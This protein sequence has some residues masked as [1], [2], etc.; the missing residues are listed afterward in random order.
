M[1]PMTPEERFESARLTREMVDLV[2]SF[3][4]G[5]TSRKELSTW[6]RDRPDDHGTLFRT[7][8][9]AGLHGCLWNCEVVLRE[10]GEPL[11]RPVDLVEHLHVVSEG[12]MPFDPEEIAV[13]TPGVREIARYVAGSATRLLLDGLGWFEGVQFASPATGRPFAAISL[14][15]LELGFGDPAVGSIVRTYRYPE[16]AEARGS[17]LADLFDTL[18]IDLDDVT[19]VRGEVS[20]RWALMRV[21]DNGNSA[22]V[23]AFSGYAKARTRLAHFETL[24]HKQTYWLE[25]CE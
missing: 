23:A 2:Q 16:S 5:G 8:A 12:E 13:I 6:A 11:I 1:K 19:S 18:A 15:A 10:T 3:L 22:V 17:V 7:A 24:H 20:D 21:D 4:E 9:T 25:R 14:H